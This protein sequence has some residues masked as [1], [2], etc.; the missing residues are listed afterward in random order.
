MITADGN[1]Y[2]DQLINLIKTR[3]NE[4]DMNLFE[5]QK[6]IFKEY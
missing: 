5:L 1:I 2:D 6:L 4:S 3:F